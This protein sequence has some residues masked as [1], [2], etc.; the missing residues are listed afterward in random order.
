MHIKRTW[1]LVV[2]LATSCA[3]HAKQSITLYES[4]DY[5]GAARAAD[6]A[7]ADHPNDDALW[8]MRVR[9]ALALGDAAGVAKAYGDYVAKRGGDDKALLRDVAIATI[10][11]ALGSPSARLKITA[12]ETVADLRILDLE[13]PVTAR[14]GDDDDRV[15]AAA[16]VAVLFDHPQA[17]EVADQ[18]LRSENPEA[19]RIALDGIAKKEQGRHHLELAV[20]E[21]EK[22]GDDPDPRVRAVALRWLGVAK[23][24][25]AVELLT[26]RLR[27]KDENVRAAAASSLARIGIGNLA[28]LGKR[29]LADKALAVRLAGIE[30]LAAARAEEALATAAGDADPLVATQAALALEPPRPE[31]TQKALDRAVAAPEWTTRAGAANLLVQGLGKAAALPVAGKLAADPEIGVR[32]AAAR[33]LARAGD[34]DRA[35]EVFAAA[36]TSDHA[37]QAAAELAGLGDPRGAAALDKLVRDPQLTPEQRAD[38]AREHATAKHVT[39]GLVAALADPSGVVRIEA[40][41]A[42]AALA[43]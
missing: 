14:I 24:R 26:R 16:A 32:L 18:M 23:D 34:R 27:D 37:A 17:P 36:L 21:L 42:I 28:E 7:L 29:A 33:A 12:I 22:S 35:R 2:A 8:G 15:A 11:Q 25:D 38:A 20:G 31:L 30:L 5:A 43:K 19:R 4:G 6:E 40:A 3:N 10:E 39:P 41:A 13:Q 1:L 9:S